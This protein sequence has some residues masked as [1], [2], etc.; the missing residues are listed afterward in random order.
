MDVSRLT[1]KY[2]EQPRLSTPATRTYNAI[3]HLIASKRIR[4]APATTTSP[5][6]YVRVDHRR[7]DVRVTQQLLN[8][9]N[10]V[11]ILY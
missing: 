6:Q 3:V 5:I 8:C 2:A 10:I 11:A 7:A 4:R 1:R 9:S